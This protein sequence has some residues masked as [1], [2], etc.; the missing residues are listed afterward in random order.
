MRYLMVLLPLLAG[1]QTV[2]VDQHRH[3]L[4]QID[5]SNKWYECIES[6][7]TVW[8]KVWESSYAIHGSPFDIVDDSDTVH[9]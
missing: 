7:G 5:D 2:E 3:Y 8:Y 6:S 1:C 9:S 4:T